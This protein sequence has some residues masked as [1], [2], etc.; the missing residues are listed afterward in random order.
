MTHQK[1]KKNY[2]ANKLSV[3]GHCR[4]DTLNLLAPAIII[5]IF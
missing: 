1:T 5:Q 4:P 2:S 3:S